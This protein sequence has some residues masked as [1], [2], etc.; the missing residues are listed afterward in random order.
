LVR[1]YAAR[2]G[3]TLLDPHLAYVTGPVPPPGVRAFEILD[4]APF[5]ERAVRAWARREQVGT[6][7]IKQRGTPV[8]PDRL[9]ARIKPAGDTRVARTLVIARIGDRARAFWCRA[10]PAD[11]R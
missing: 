2:H 3:L 4:A 10:V 11:A 7:E 6:L 1:H 9:R 5:T 8:I